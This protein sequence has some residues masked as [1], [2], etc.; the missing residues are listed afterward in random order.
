MR[1]DNDG[2]RDLKMET[3]GLHKP[4]AGVRLDARKREDDGR[5]LMII[6]VCG[7]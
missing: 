7:R 1:V 4:E 2:K 5:R 6:R 3:S